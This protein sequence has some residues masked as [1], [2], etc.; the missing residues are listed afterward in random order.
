MLQLAILLV[1]LL[2]L[3]RV[4]AEEAFWKRGVLIRLLRS[5]DL[6]NIVNVRVSVSETLSHTISWQFDFAADAS[7]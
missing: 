3:F 7:Q 6:H 1:V 5:I 2:G 4:A